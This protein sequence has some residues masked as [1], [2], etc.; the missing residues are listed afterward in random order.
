[1]HNNKLINEKLICAFRWS[2]LPSI[3]KILCTVFT[4][5]QLLATVTVNDSDVCHFNDLNLKTETGPNIGVWSISIKAYPV[6]VQ[7]WKIPLQY[8]FLL[9]NFLFLAS[10]FQR[11]K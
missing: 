5:E 2:V 9:K 4:E 6:V 3:M 8:F 10:E 1:L 11:R 7:R